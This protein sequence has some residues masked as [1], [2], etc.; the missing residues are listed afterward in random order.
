MAQAAV[1]VVGGDNGKYHIISLFFSMEQ[2]EDQTQQH[3]LSV[4]HYNL[5]L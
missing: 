4:Q 1:V 3:T 5:S 2:Q